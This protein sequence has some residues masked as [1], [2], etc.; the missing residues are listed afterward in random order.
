MGLH[1]TLARKITMEGLRPVPRARKS[2]PCPVCGM[3]KA[4]AT[5]ACPA[6][7]AYGAR[8]PS[9]EQIQ[10]QLAEVVGEVYD[11]AA[12]P[13][14]QGLSPEV[15][16]EILEAFDGVEPPKV[17]VPAYPPLYA[18]QFRE[19]RA[20]GIDTTLVERI[21]VEQGEGAFKAQFAAII[22]RQVGKRR[23]NGQFLCPLC[24][25]PLSPDEPE[26][27]NCGAKFG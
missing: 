10:R 13:D 9:T 23:A 5:G 1:H 22:R 20:R 8:E 4:A 3:A 27:E 17:P 21:L 12:D 6:C 24:D 25:D 16:E 7:G 18:T 15:R 2:V 14:F 19:W 11:L 26:C